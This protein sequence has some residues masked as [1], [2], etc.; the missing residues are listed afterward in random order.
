MFI[1]R[2]DAPPFRNVTAAIAPSPC[3]HNHTLDKQ[4][5]NPAYS[6]SNH[7]RICT[8]SQRPDSWVNKMMVNRHGRLRD[9]TMQTHGLHA[10]VQCECN[11]RVT[12]AH[13]LQTVG[14]SHDA[15]DL[16]QDVLDNKHDKPPPHAEFLADWDTH[17]HC[18][19]GIENALGDSGL[20][21]VTS[22][23]QTLNIPLINAKR[24][25]LLYYG[26]TLVTDQ[27]VV[28]FPNDSYAIWHVGIGENYV[29]GFLMSKKG[30][31][32][33]LE[34]HNDRPHWHQPLSK[35]CG[36]VYIL[37]RQIDTDARGQSLFHITGFRIP[38]GTGLYTGKGAIHCD[39]G[40][41]GQNWLIGY[42][43]SDDFSTVVVR[44]SNGE[45]IRFMP[46]RHSA[47]HAAGNAQH[48]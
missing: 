45:M 13:G 18:Y 37:A 12:K 4:T 1:S 24:P 20:L 31:G 39:P 44:N 7:K 25:A 33:Y 5:P 3:G 15:I 2:D 21:T 43:E 14:A 29:D 27:S 34:Y 36:G 10:M 38:Y 8:L 26:A 22:Q 9:S 23:N 40:L 35:S 41:T 28:R 6:E 32:F 17:L 16:E 19:G 42:D 46:S 11:Y 30:N 47:C 48:H